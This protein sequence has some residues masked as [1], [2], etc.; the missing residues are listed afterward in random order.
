MKIKRRPFN[1]NTIALTSLAIALISMLWNTFYG[2]GKLSVRFD[3]MQEDIA[4]DP[5]NPC[6]DER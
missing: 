4:R 2:Y 1:S 3:A 5:I 6:Q